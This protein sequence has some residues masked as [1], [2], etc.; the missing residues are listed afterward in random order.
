M[1][2]NDSGGPIKGPW[3]FF[4]LVFDQNKARHQRKH[5]PD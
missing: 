4:Q 2:T 1:F 3:G 5:F